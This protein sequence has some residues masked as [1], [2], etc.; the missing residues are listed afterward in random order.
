M[1]ENNEILELMTKLYAEVKE[2]QITLEKVTNEN[3]KLIAEGNYKL[4]RRL[5]DVLIA[6]KEKEMLLIRV[7]ILE[8]EVRKLKDRIEEIA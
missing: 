2:I 4:N 5:D 6:E 3:I 8:N 1:N 7:T